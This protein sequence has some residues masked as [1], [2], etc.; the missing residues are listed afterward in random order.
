MNN[1]QF[2]IFGFPVRIEMFFFLTMWLIAGRAGSS[3]VVIAVAAMAGGSLMVHELGH[4]FAFRRFGGQDIFIRLVAF[5]G[6]TSSRGGQYTPRQSLVISAAGVTAEAIFVAL[7]A[8]LALTLLD[9]VGEVRTVLVYAVW[10]NVIWIIFNLLPILDLDGGHIV[11]HLARIVTGKDQTIPIRY[12]SVLVGSG[13]ALLGGLAGQFFVS[14]FMG[15]MVFNN[16]KAI[17]VSRGQ[18]QAADQYIDV[19]SRPAGPPPSS[20]PPSSGP[21]PSRGASSP[22]GGLPPTAP[23]TAPPSAPP[24]GPRQYPPIG[25]QD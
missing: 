20:P 1:P 16:I 23:P 13:V 6:Y 22:F 12:V 18:R 5:G 7:P 15:F 17:I 19:D 14:I 24:S 21:A 9:P 2:S 25:R 3:G 8:Y 10:L 11:Q 4:A